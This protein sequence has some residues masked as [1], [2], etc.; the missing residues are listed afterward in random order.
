[1]LWTKGLLITYS[2]S[3]EAYISAPWSPGADRWPLELP[4]STQE[5]SSSQEQLMILRTVELHLGGI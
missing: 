3:L 5:V 1:M 4:G 2:S